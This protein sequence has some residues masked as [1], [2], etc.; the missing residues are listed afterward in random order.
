MSNDQDYINTNLLNSDNTGVNIAQDIVVSTVVTGLVEDSVK[1]VI[2]NF[3]G[4]QALNTAFKKYDAKFT[5]EM[6]ER[7]SKRASQKVTG[8]ITKRMG[9]LFAKKSAQTVLKSLGKTAAGAAARAGAITAGGCTAGPAGCAAGAAI[10]GI[11][12]VAD[13]AFTIFSTLLDIRDTEGILNVFHKDYIEEISKDFKEALNAGYADMGYPGLM[14]EEVEFYP[15]AFVFNFDE[16]GNVFID[17]SDEWTQKYLQYRDEYIRNLGISDGWEERL[18]S[19]EVN[20][21]NYVNNA[22]KPSGNGMF[23]SLS[24][25]LVSCCCLILF[26]LLLLGNE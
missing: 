5:K 26:S 23:M 3:G 24:S 20:I 10:G 16:D 6:M 4:K 2:Y 18:N 14:D 17:K 11:I 21:D 9:Q 15:D 22:I 13:L 12:F 8:S 25:S 19:T 1:G 7:L